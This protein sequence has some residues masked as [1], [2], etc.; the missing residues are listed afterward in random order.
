[1]KNLT[2]YNSLSLQGHFAIVLI[3]IILVSCSSDD[4]DVAPNDQFMVAIPSSASKGIVFENQAEG[5]QLPIRIVGHLVNSGTI[6]VSITPQADVQYGTDFTTEPD[7]S[8]GSVTLN[9]SEGSASAV[10]SVFPS[11]EAGFNTDKLINFKLESVSG[12]LFLATESVDYE[13]AIQDESLN[14][15]ILAF[16]SFEEPAAG[17]VN[18]Y[19]APDSTFLPNNP[20]ENSVDYVS[21]GGEMGFDTSYLPGEEGGEDTSLIFG[22]TNVTNEPDEYNIGAFFNGS[23][24]YVTSDADGLAEIVFDEVEI[25]SKFNSLKVRLSVY[26]VD[27][28]W[29]DDDEFDVFWRTE[30]GDE[31]LMSFRSNGELM[32]DSPDGTGNVLVDDWFTFNRDVTNMKKGRLVIQIGT[33][34]GSEYAFIDDIVIG[35]VE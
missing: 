17:D 3:F 35:G 10:L 33:N 20:G 25:P 9:I 7:G 18:N 2:I 27:A 31:T 26:F 1:M 8:S 22:V 5:I 28:S 19:S 4:F 14:V 11:V 21:T 15:D 23:Q 6:T 32:T 16:T 30:D 12:G 29:E 34:S 13:L 24:A